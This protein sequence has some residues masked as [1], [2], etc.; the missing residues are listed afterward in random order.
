MRVLNTIVMGSTAHTTL[1]RRWHADYGTFTGG[2]NWIFEGMLPLY[3]RIGAGSCDNGLIMWLP[4]LAPA[5][6]KGNGMLVARASH[7]KHLEYIR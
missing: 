4:V 2:N 1:P 7:A 3:S 5:V 6:P